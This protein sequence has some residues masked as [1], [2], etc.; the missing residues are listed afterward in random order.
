MK[1]K[2]KRG[3][4]VLLILVA[5]M[6]GGWFY[7]DSLAYKVC[8][9][10]AGITVTPSDFLKTPD[11]AAIFTPESQPFEITEP[12][13]YAIRVKSG[14]F[15]HSCTLII[16][17]T[18]IPKGKPQDV[19][20][21]YGESCQ[22]ADFV[23]DIQDMTQVNVTFVEEPDFTKPGKQPVKIL[24]TD[25]GN[26]VL[27]LQADLNISRVMEELVWEAGDLD[28][29]V[30]DFLIKVGE[31][32]ILTDMS[33][34]NLNVIGDYPVTILA[35]DLEWKAMLQVRDTIAPAGTVQSISG[36]ALVPRQPEAFVLQI[37]DV[38]NVSVS[39]AKEPDLSLIGTQTVELLLTDEGK[40]QTVLQTQL[41]LEADT[42]APVINGVQDILIYVGDTISYRRGVSVEDNCEE[43]LVFEIDNSQVNP[44]EAGMYPVTYTATDLAGNVTQQEITVTINPRS[45][46]QEEIDALA[47]EV[48]AQIITPEM[49]QLD[50]VQAIYNY[51]TSHVGYINHSQKG[52][53]IQA[54][55]EGLSKRKGDCY[56]YACTAKQLLT[57]AGIT[58][59]D[60]AKI[61]T[62]STHYWNLVDI[63][64]GWYHFDTTPR[65]DHP[66]IFMW[67]DEQLMEY[68]SRHWKSHNYDPTLYP[69]IN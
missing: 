46:T 41:H 12:G 53:W 64:D 36:F 16:E 42:Q 8:R 20:L 43:G 7:I 48:L 6:A 29:C 32:E 21:T 26:N 27:T 47:D 33:E 11:E 14:W 58:N 4:F 28:I 37:E 9:V 57:R 1:R 23:T 54:A 59:M 25:R 24:L 39:Y 19:F 34:I 35:D 51:I 55:W 5:V 10:E 63:G 44:G 65:K 18:Q 45:H 56:V 13:E 3:L 69:E 60:I 40:N 62:R 17:D 66:V 49:T 2:K 31:A 30:N 61:P 22:A 50:K 68:S 15:T 67:T 52:D 38:T